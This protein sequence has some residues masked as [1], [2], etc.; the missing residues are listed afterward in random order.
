MEL[1]P[2]RCALK[3][4]CQSL[5]ARRPKKSMMGGALA[6]W[7]TGRAR[8]LCP[9]APPLS[10]GHHRDGRPGAA[11]RCRVGRRPR[12]RPAGRQQ[13]L[14]LMPPLHGVQPAARVP[15]NDTCTHE[16]PGQHARQ[17]EEASRRGGGARG[18]YTYQE[19]RR[20]RS[21]RKR[22]W[23]RA[24]AHAS[25]GQS[26]TQPNGAATGSCRQ[27]AT[28]RRTKAGE[29]TPAEADPWR[30]RGRLAGL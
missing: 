3:D 14:R 24:P 8:D 17:T 23:P 21:R 13:H 19:A 6:N 25:G 27:A 26:P 9:E 7:R 1:S 2:P 12:R 29:A 11:R 4:G 30:A 16:I 10:A 5:T 20:A 28:Q 22:S 15:C 18:G